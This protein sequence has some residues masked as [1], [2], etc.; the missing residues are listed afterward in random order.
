MADLDLLARLT[1][2]GLEFVGSS[3]E[4]A[5]W[6]GPLMAAIFGGV[7]TP[8]WEP[9]GVLADSLPPRALSSRAGV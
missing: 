3:A 8:D 6:E 7:P 5:T 2:Q 4:V 9:Q 1:R